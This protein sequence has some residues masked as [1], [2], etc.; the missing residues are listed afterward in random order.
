MANNSVIEKWK[1][2]CIE[3]NKFH[4]VWAEERPTTCPMNMAH[5]VN[6][7]LTHVD[8][9]VEADLVLVREENIETFEQQTN[10]NYTIRSHHISVEPG[11]TVT[12]SEETFVYPI[13]MLD[14]MIDLTEN[15]NGDRLYVDIGRNTII[16]GL[17]AP[18]TP[19]AS[20]FVVSPTVTQYSNNGYILSL[21]PDGVNF[22]EIGPILNTD[23]VN[24]V[25][26]VQN[27]DTNTWPPGT[28]VAIS[29]RLCD[30]DIGPSPWRLNMG[31]STIGAVYVPAGRKLTGTYINR[32]G[33]GEEKHVH[34]YYEYFY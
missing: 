6:H 23:P 21:S 25:L 27:N 4:Y 17:Y 19:G 12:H 2:F 30:V 9:R 11:V 26:T 10:K 33:N 29:I 24:N 3:E 14:V 28:F 7:E 15:M 22:T 18:V 34:I 13:S 5:T 20:T 1:V 32:N 31:R 16:G 8:H